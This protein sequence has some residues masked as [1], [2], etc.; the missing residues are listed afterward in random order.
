M[1]YSPQPVDSDT[2]LSDEGSDQ[3]CLS[4][5]QERL[6]HWNCCVWFLI[7]VFCAMIISEVLAWLRQPVCGQANFHWNQVIPSNTV[8]QIE[9]GNLGS[10]LQEYDVLGLWT[11]LWHFDVYENATAL[12]SSGADRQTKVFR[13]AWSN[14]HLLF[15]FLE[16]M[17]YVDE[18]GPKKLVAMEGRKLW[19]TIGSSFEL[20]LCSEG[21]LSYEISVD[22]PPWDLTVVYN[23]HQMPSRVLV[24]QT[25]FQLKDASFWSDDSHWEAVV[26]AANGG[27][28]TEG[29]VIG[30][31]KQNI[32]SFDSKWF[33]MNER[34]DLLPNEVLSFMTLVY[35]VD[36]TRQS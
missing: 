31:V 15:G 28:D 12:A 7:I 17:A 22:S 18:T 14:G 2:E 10:M 24:A 29:Q 19:G 32:S 25:R 3:R 27:N 36:E 21:Q 26:V 4:K 20:W 1:K 34:P 23:I 6:P 33:V 5:V 8:N 13:G 30:K 9:R 11:K 16:K 35:D